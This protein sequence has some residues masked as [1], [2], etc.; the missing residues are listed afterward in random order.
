MRPELKET[1]ECPCCTNDDGPR[2]R[3]CDACNGTKQI[4]HYRA[5]SENL[6]PGDILYSSC[7]AEE[8]G[9]V[10]LVEYDLEP[11]LL[12]ILVRDINPMFE[13]ECRP[14]VYEGWPFLSNT[15][16]TFE[17][18]EPILVRHVPIDCLRVSQVC[19]WEE[20][21][22][23]YMLQLD[24]PWREHSCNRCA[25][26]FTILRPSLVLPK[27]SYVDPTWRGRLS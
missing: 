3:L 23:G 22:T 25:S 5:T 13:W 4:H 18:K 21:D 8:F 26:S 15:R 9:K 14:V 17:H 20:R 7:S 11:Q 2:A 24:A 1:I 12:D 16:P 27:A 6:R 19:E 10:V